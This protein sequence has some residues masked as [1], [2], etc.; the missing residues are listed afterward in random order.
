M[1][2]VA[3]YLGQQKPSYANVLKILHQ[4]STFRCLAA[5]DSCSEMEIVGRF[6]PCLFGS[7]NS[8]ALYNYAC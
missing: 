5:A 2:G 6:V 3:I 1:V 4:F 8:F 7:C